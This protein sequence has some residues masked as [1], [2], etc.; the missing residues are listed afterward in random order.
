MIALLVFK[1][2]AK[3]GMFQEFKKILAD[4]SLIHQLIALQGRKG[5]LTNNNVIYLGK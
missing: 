4:I 2:F 1:S 3:E 5:Y